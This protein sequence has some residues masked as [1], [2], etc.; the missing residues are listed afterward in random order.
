[1]VFF[2]RLPVAQKLLV[3]VIGSALLLAGTLGVLNLQKFSEDSRAAESAKLLGIAESRRDA[4]KDYLV[5]LDQDIQTVATNP[6]TVE[7]LQAFEAGWG[8]MEGN[9][10]TTLKRLYIEDNPFPTGQ[11]EEL[12]YASD[13][14]LYSQAHASYHDWFRS[15]LRARGYY[16]IFLFSNDGSLVYSVFKELDYATNLRSGEYQDTDLGNSF[17][18]A[19]DG[20][21]VGELAFYDFKPYAPSHGA[22]ASFLSTPIPDGNGGVAGVLVFQ[23]PIDRLNHVME[24]TAGL[25]QSGEAFVVGADNLMRTDAPKAGESTLLKA[26]V[27][28][29][30]KSGGSQLVEAVGYDGDTVLARSAE[31]SFH[32]IDWTIVSQIDR[33]EAMAPVAQM[34]TRMLMTTGVLLLIISA[35]GVLLARRISKPLKD[36]ADVTQE[37]AEGA[38]DIEVPHKGRSDEIGPL[39]RSIDVFREAMIRSEELAEQ[40]RLQAV[41]DQKEAE[42]RARRGEHLAQLTARFDEIVTATLAEV[43]S[44]TARLDDSAAAMAAIAEETANQS[45]VVAGASQSASSNVQSVAA[46]TEELS[47]SV[48]EIQSKVVHARDATSNAVSRAGIM[49]ERVASLESAAASISDVVGL[50]TNI[51]GQTNLL[52]LNATIEA[53]RAGEAGKGF[54]VVAS[55][56]KALAN[57]TSSATDDI[58]RQIGEIQSTTEAS[59]AG[60]QAI[61]DA[62][63]DLEQVSSEIASA[64]EQQSGA[65]R[66]ISANIQEAAGGVQQVDANIDGVSTAANEAGETAALVRDSSGKLGL[67]ADRLRSEVEKFLAEVRAA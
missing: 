67:E 56:V 65:T 51:A 34:R 60:I 23:M 22:P 50:I 16:D 33:S 3:L 6:Y 37:I 13:G 52:A 61:L 12:D 44:A 5:S 59:V 40:Q 18:A 19:A 43:G 41:R 4:L 38:R 39:A 45:S 57:Q 66:L 32:G 30:F 9:P 11:K 25:G 8:A 15:F 47:V 26:S 64:I 36:I 48:E 54:A 49:R 21:K 24:S 46:A 55:E 10:E 29:V 17:R 53:A 7:A 58:S 20:L 31:L 42:E 35:L 63:G 62:I 1:M 27:D 28:D 2:D 14:S